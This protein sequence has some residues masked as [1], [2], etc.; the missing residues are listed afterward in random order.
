MFS[1]QESTCQSIYVY[2]KSYLGAF[3]LDWIK[4]IIGDNS[5]SQETSFLTAICLPLEYG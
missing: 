5:I 4:L 3:L 1:F 2:K